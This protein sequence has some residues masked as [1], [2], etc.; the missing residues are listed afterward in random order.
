MDRSRPH[1]RSRQADRN[2]FWPKLT[3]AILTPAPGGSRNS[4]A[5]EV[6]NVDQR[7]ENRVWLG[8]TV[9]SFVLTCG[10]GASCTTDDSGGDSDETVNV[11]GRGR[12]DSGGN[13]TD[14]ARPTG[15]AG[16]DTATD[17]DLPPRGPFGAVRGT[18]WAPGNAPGLVPSGQEIP[19]SGAL[20]YLSEH[21]PPAIPDRAYCEQCLDPPGRWLFTDS[22]GDFEMLNVIVGNY[23]LVM[24]KGQFRRDIQIAVYED[25]V[26]DL[27]TDLTTL[28]S[29]HDPEHGRWTPRI[30]M[31]VG[32]HDQL[33]DILGKLGLG[34]VDSDGEYLRTAT[35][36]RVHIWENGGWGFDAV[37]FGTLSQLVNDLE[38]MLQYHI[39]FIPCSGTE[40]TSALMNQAVLRNI[41]DYVQAGGK[42]YVT[43]WSG[44]WNDNVFPEQVTLG[45]D[46][47]TPANAYDRASDTWTTWLFGDAD[48]S[49]YDSPNAEAVDEDLHAWLDGQEG[50]VA[51]YYDTQQ[52]FNASSFV[53]E[54]NWNVINNLTT[55]H[56]GTDL[57]GEPIY[58]TPHVWVRGGSDYEPEPKK[59]LTVTY[60]PAG[61]GR[62]LFSTYH[63]TDET[64]VGLTPQERVLVYL[65]MEIGVCRSGKEYA[66][67]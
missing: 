4:V 52:V 38:Q 37:S 6:A 53:A 17:E 51:D 2:R 64:H 10:L 59:P 56:V 61:C 16:D 21:P 50:P 22:H 12:R 19:I 5:N 23:W 39:I 26:V 54:G 46:E 24:Q 29:E 60:E 8:I 1:L 55:V 28:P 13:G 42:L 43:D 11:G 62:V 67:P 40:N 36:G 41:R 48:G 34:G 15:D 14:L 9:L 47:D 63:T 31:A 18:L 25:Q 32:N 66:D 49:S 58:D 7:H 65:I 27:T 3:G 20:V 35:S 30:A 44:E 57:E 33:E 45:P